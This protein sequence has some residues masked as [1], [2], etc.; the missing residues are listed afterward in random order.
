MPGQ[1][2]ELDREIGRRGRVMGGIARRRHSYCAGKVRPAA[3]KD[4]H[5][6][7]QVALQA[8]PELSHGHSCLP[9]KI[10]LAR[11]SGVGAL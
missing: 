9:A 6:Q 11:D 7:V 3:Q 2:L 5:P 10:F 8:A 1:P 4:P